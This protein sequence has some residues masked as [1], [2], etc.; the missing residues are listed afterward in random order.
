MKFYWARNSRAFRI[1]WLLEELGQPYERIVIDIRQPVAERPAQFLAVS[2][3]GKV[4]ALE[5]GEARLTDS[6]AICL[7]LAERFPEAGLAPPPGT[8]ARARFLQ[9]LL[10]TNTSVEPAMAEKFSGMEPR[11]SSHGWG[12]YDSVL[13]QFRQGLAEGP[14]ILGTQ[15]T[16]ADVLLGTGAH[17]LIQFG[18]AKGDAVLEAYVARCQAR[19]AFQRAQAFDA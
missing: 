7:W 8:A 1:A 19:P 15:F 3:L 13:A 2:P 12:S 5:D 9:W 18:L 10:F 17:F 4:P 16:S 14:W 6:G 11:P